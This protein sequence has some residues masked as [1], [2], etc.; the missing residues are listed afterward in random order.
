MRPRVRSRV[1]PLALLGAAFLAAC[2]DVTSPPVELRSDGTPALEAASS[3]LQE[4]DRYLMLFDGPVPY[5]FRKRVADVGGTLVFQHRVG[6]AVVSGIDAPVAARL[7]RAND[8]VAVQPD[9]SFELEPVGGLRTEAAGVVASATDPTQAFFYARQWNMRAVEADKAWAAGRLGSVTRTVA[10]LD[11]GIDYLY[12]DLRGLVDLR[13]SVSFIPSDDQLVAQMFPDRHPITDLNFHGTHVA[14]TA[15]SNGDVIA[16]VTSRLRLMGVKVC[17]VTGSCPF[18]SVIQGILHAVDNRADVINMSLGGAFD[19]TQ[20]PDFADFIDRVFEAVGAAGTVVVVSSGNAGLDMDTFPGIY[21]TYCDAPG[22]ICVAATGPTSGGTAGPW[23]DP[24]AP[25]LYSNI[26]SNVTV[27]APGGN[28]GAPVWAACSTTSL[29][30]PVCQTGTFVLGVNGTSMAAPHVSG[31]AGILVEKYGN[32][33]AAV[34]AA[35]LS[36]GDAVVPPGFGAVRINV[37]GSLGLN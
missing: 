1:A 6:I 8:I 19:A 9:L 10:I 30:V 18:S 25:A 12:P 2:A 27:A 13:R 15:V 37:A 7:G 16:G 20:F 33:P 22:V 28:T 32:N 26:G 23:P 35:L 3:V 36:G 11:T 17:D 29:V 14:S 4:G 31:L 24:D 34:R 21:F 5:N